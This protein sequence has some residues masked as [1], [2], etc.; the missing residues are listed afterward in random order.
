MGAVKR[1]H[2]KALMIGEVSATLELVSELTLD[3]FKRDN[4]KGG[5]RGAMVEK[6]KQPR[7]RF[8]FIKLL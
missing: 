1:M 2:G 3:T 8:L 6:E 5:A 7:A 4:I